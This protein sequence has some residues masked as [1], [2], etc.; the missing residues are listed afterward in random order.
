[1]LTFLGILG[2]SLAALVLVQ[3]A[4]IE[5]VNP[6]KRRKPVPLPASKAISLNAVTGA[7]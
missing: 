4:G 1:M 3:Q 5:C 7:R 2:L 6:P